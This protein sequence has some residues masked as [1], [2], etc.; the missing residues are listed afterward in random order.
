MTNYNAKDMAFYSLDTLNEGDFQIEDGDFR[1]TGYQESPRQD[2]TNRIRTQQTDWRSHPRIGADLE[3]FIGEPNTRETASKIN[4]SI[5][6]TLLYDG[7]FKAQDVTNRPVPLS[8]THID[9]YTMIDTNDNE[10]L[11]LVTP[12]DL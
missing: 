4:T 9:V 1:L 6:N 2:A 3:L 10:P 5:L 8:T 7:R 11:L 12:V